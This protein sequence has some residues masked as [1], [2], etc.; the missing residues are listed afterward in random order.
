MRRR[1]LVRVGGEL[2][3]EV[4]ADTVHGQRW[5]GDEGTYRRSPATVPPRPE[6]PGSDRFRPGPPDRPTGGAERVGNWTLLGGGGDRGLLSGKGMLR[7]LLTTIERPRGRRRSRK[8][9]EGGKAKY[10]GWD[11]FG[12]IFRTRGNLKHVSFLF[13][14]I[15]QSL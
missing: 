15:F 4:G 1:T 6:S 2:G 13:Q 14:S 5:V 8:E 7:P 10:L 12:S 11:F 3:G 9:C